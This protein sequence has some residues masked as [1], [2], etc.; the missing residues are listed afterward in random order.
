MRDRF[1]DDITELATLTELPIKRL[2]KWAGVHKGRFYD[3]R[4]RY[5]KVNEHN[6]RI[7]RDHWLEEWEQQAILAYHDANPL[8]GYRR[9]TYMMIDADVVAASP[10]TV[11]RVL[12]ANGRLDRWN[13]GPSRKGTGFA[14][15]SGPHRHWHI[16]IAY[17]NI[18]ATFYYLFTVLDGFSR[19]IVHWHIGETMTEADVELELQRAVEKHPDHKPRVISDNGPQFIARDFRTFIRLLGMTHV[20]TSVNYPQ[21]NG[22]LERWHKS[23]KQEAIRPQ[24]LSSLDEAQARVADFVE[25]YNHHRLH[26]AI[27]YITPADKLAGRADV[28]LAERDRKLEVARERR[29]ARRR[30]KADSVSIEPTVAESTRSRSSPS[31]ACPSP[32]ASVA[33][34]GPKPTADA[35]GEGLADPR[36]APSPRPREQGLGDTPSGGMIDL[37][38]PVAERDSVALRP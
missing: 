26:S 14:Q 11:Y 19:Y 29:A 33:P 27:D 24:P 22:K 7:P 12:K 3:W 38:G 36:P 23:L 20:R 25:V 9:L 35:D 10:S 21:S 15:P 31:S 32:S 16:D 8:N 13:P 37:H 1:V 5:G 30:A 17:I 6:G 34:H 2:L 4:K 18:C 28:I